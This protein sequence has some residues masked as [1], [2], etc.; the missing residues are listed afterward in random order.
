MGWDLS[1]VLLGCCPLAGLV[2]GYFWLLLGTLCS[3]NNCVSQCLL[4]DLR[5]SGIVLVARWFRRGSPFDC[6]LYISSFYIDVS[7]TQY[8]LFSPF[9]SEDYLFAN[10]R[11][12]SLPF[13]GQ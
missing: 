5:H 11:S 9:Y 6:K 8:T 4:T 12:I 2:V 10:T 7:I 1:G 13:A 3:A